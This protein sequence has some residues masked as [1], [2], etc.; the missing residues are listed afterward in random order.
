MCRVLICD[1][2]STSDFRWPLTGK[3]RESQGGTHEEKVREIHEKYVESQGKMK[4]FCKSVDIAHFISVFCL[5]II[6]IT[7]NDCYSVDKLESWGCES[8]KSQQK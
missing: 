1:Y 8:G 6:V 3:S 7:V 4:L 2:S 5:R